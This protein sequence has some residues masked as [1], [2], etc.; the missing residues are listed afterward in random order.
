MV[1][2][3]ADSRDASDGDDEGVDS[4]R[5][6]AATNSLSALAAQLALYFVVVVFVVSV[7]VVTAAVECM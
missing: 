1:W 5:A 4:S 7:R 3:N 6:I 2:T